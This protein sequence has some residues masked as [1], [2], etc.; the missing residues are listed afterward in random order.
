M[1]PSLQQ[2]RQQYFY[3]ITGDA[4]I[5]DNKNDNRF[6]QEGVRFPLGTKGSIL[7]QTQGWKSP[8]TG[9]ITPLYQN[10]PGVVHAKFSQG[11]HTPSPSNM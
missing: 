11:K 6:S 5:G 9:E 3:T 4:K 1:D 8:V 10:N 2:K 7:T